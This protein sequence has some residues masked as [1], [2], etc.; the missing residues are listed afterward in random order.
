MLY[1]PLVLLCLIKTE[2]IVSV[3]LRSLLQQSNLY[4][5]F[6]F[7]FTLCYKDRINSFSTSEAFGP[8]VYAIFT[9]SFTLC[10]KDRI[11]SFRT[12]DVFVP[13]V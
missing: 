12:S 3:L 13:I 7:S 1:L 8:I 2:S 5:I 11:H 10:Y 6:T 4:A 9:F